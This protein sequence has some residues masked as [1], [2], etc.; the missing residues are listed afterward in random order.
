M[1][2]IRA[3][4][5]GLGYWG[6]ILCKTIASSEGMSLSAVAD[7]HPEN[8]APFG[9]VTQYVDSQALINDPQIQMVV[10]ATQTSSHEALVR[11]ALNNS[12]HVFV[13]KPFTGS[14]STAQE[15]TEVA[16]ARGLRIF[17]D[18]PYL[19]SKKMEVLQKTLAGK[20]V[21]FVKM[22]RC[23]FGKFPRDADV[24]RHLMF[25]DLYI[26]NHLLGGLD[27]RPGVISSS[28]RL[29]SP[30]QSDW[31]VA[32]FSLPVGAVV[33]I[34]CDMTSLEKIRLIEFHCHDGQ[35][36]WDDLK[37]EWLSFQKKRAVLEG[38]RFNYLAA[39]SMP[40]SGSELRGN[41]DPLLQQFEYVSQSLRVGS[42]AINDAAVAVKVLQALD[43]LG[44]S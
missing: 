26:V 11:A 5:V 36:C 34:T 28:G 7:R 1:E 12:K 32:Q 35:Y 16:K 22:H 33:H 10:I 3:G 2:K 42:L 8:L 24:F 29:L 31:G 39:E 13:E 14:T 18:M 21:E 43:A 30:W 9:G 27:L 44:R 19:F 15:L 6:K 4:V 23:D 37:K 40:V 38:D 25:H 20:V 17:V 41:D